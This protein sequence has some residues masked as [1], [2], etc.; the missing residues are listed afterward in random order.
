[1]QQKE[2]RSPVK[3]VEGNPRYSGCFCHIAQL[4]QYNGKGWRKDAGR[5]VS[6]DFRDIPCTLGVP[7]G[8]GMPSKNICHIF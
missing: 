4:G 3:E 5:R 2:K 1:M 8:L 7:W 6:K